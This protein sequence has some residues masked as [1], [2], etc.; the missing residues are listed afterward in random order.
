M[1]WLQ[2]RCLNITLKSQTK[3]QQIDGYASH[4]ARIFNDL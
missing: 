1:V 4:E 2:K 3:A